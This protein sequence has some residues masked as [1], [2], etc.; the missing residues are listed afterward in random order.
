M[1]NVLHLEYVSKGNAPHKLWRPDFGTRWKMNHLLS[2]SSLIGSNS[3]IYTE[4]DATK[5]ARC[6]RRL[7]VNHQLRIHHF[8]WQLSK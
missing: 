8:R 6:S 3:S 5:S 1:Y 7:N 4:C 2:L